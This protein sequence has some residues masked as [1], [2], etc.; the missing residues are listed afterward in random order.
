MIFCR[1][2]GTMFVF[3]LFFI[4]SSILDVNANGYPPIP[5]FPTT[6]RDVNGEKFN[7]HKRLDEQRQI[8]CADP[9]GGNNFKSLRASSCDRCGKLPIDKFKVVSVLHISLLWYALFPDSSMK[10][11]LTILSCFKMSNVLIIVLSSIIFF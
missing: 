2:S 6:C 11:I 9:K 10:W 8:S 4:V 3:L 5:I 7:F 1:N